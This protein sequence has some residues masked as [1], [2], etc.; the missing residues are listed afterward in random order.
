MIK[1]QQIHLHVL[2]VRSHSATNI[3]INFATKFATKNEIGLIPIFAT[4]YL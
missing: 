1:Y 3:A 2:M 4:K